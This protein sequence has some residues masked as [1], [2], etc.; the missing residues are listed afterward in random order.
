M[1]ESNLDEVFCAYL[2]GTDKYVM[3][4]TANTPIGDELI[5]YDA[6]G[7]I[8]APSPACDIAGDPL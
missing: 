4:Y 3:D 1:V 7:F 5:E 6:N 2:P 8:W